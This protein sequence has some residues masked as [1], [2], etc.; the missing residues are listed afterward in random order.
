VVVRLVGNLTVRTLNGGLRIVLEDGRP[1]DAI[2][3]GLRQFDLAK[4]VEVL[5]TLARSDLVELDDGSIVEVTDE[6]RRTVILAAHDAAH[7]RKLG[8]RRLAMLAD[9]CA[10]FSV[11][12]DAWSGWHANSN[13]L[14][15]WVTGE[16]PRPPEAEGMDVCDCPSVE[17][18]ARMDLEVVGS[19]LDEVYGLSRPRGR[20]RRVH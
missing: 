17:E 11:K 18:E 4:R 7:E 19:M 2:A 9:F 14:H 1:I 10:A 20:P 6:M 3:E 16:R 13:G 12:T 15:V 8:V 5:T